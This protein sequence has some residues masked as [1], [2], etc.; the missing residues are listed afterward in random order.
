MRVLE[1][2]QVCGRVVL[3][4]FLFFSS[5]VKG[6][7]FNAVIIKAAGYLPNTS[8]PE[9]PDALTQA[10]SEGGNT[11]TFA[12]TLAG[13]LTALKVQSEIV[14]FSALEMRHF[15]TQ[16]IVFAG[17]T[18]G[19]KFP[20]QLQKIVPGLKDVIQSDSR[21]VCTEFTSC[22]NSE[23]GERAIQHFDALLNEAGLNTCKGIAISRDVGT[24]SLNQKTTEF[25][26]LL[27]EALKEIKM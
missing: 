16:L 3:C 2:I 24:K 23:A 13:K 4:A 9:N 5:C 20:E 18:Y 10:T 19:G 6:P 27:L 17:P 7:K 8:A 12:D 11:H 14:D 25:A 1:R 22:R 15:N 21:I 26:G